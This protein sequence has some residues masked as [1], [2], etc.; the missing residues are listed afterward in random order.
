MRILVALSAGVVIGVV[1]IEAISAGASV[2]L[3][4]A[5]IRVQAADGYGGR[6]IWPLLPV[7]ALIWSFAGL[8]GGAMAAAVA[9]RASWGLAVGGLLAIPAFVL[10]GL[11]TPGNPLALLAAAI[12]LVGSA[13]GTVAVI[14]MR[15]QDTTVTANDQAV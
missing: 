2:V 9:P 11:V 6:P 3:P 4:E 5:A 12:P 13:A 1:L 7:P 8:A 14:R 15:H 10:V